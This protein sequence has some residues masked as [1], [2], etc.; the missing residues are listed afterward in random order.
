MYISKIKYKKRDFKSGRLIEWKTVINTIKN[1]GFER[2][3]FGYGTGNNWTMRKEAKLSDYSLTNMYE[4]KGLLVSAAHNFPLEIMLGSGLLGIISL[5]LFFWAP[6]SVKSKE[7]H[8]I[9]IKGGFL[10]VI[11]VSMF[12][13]L[14]G[15]NTGIPLILF[16]LAGMLMR[17]YQK[18]IYMK[19]SVII[20]VAICFLFFVSIGNRILKSNI[21][22]S[23]IA[24]SDIDKAIKIDPYQTKWIYK[25]ALSSQNNIE[26][27]KLLKN[28]IKS[29]P[30]CL[31][32][33][34]DYRKLNGGN[35]YWELYEIEHKFS[36]LLKA[37]VIG[38]EILS[39]KCRKSEWMGI[40]SKLDSYC[41]LNKNSNILKYVNL[42]KAYCEWKNPKIQ[43][44]YLKKIEKLRE[45]YIA[46]F[47]K[48][49]GMKYFRLCKGL[50]S[51]QAD[52]NYWKEW[53]ISLLG[54]K[55]N[56]K[57]LKG[58]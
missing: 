13:S 5:I 9:G 34:D 33:I 4:L 55:Y 6:L 49:L 19:N 14:I 11:I 10:S 39:E 23:L 42:A 46:R 28:A 43:R 57:V 50:R 37:I 47:G 3:L 53:A 52:D 2:Y 29:D 22:S 1:G 18:E 30:L 41:R 45:K 54:M 27:I 16:L 15:K 51:W 48:K 20:F 25:K 36:N 38:P 17:R 24:K 31:N 32:V 35:Y 58:E 44:E 26:K 8:I 7:T 21:E 56:K 40:F 12:H